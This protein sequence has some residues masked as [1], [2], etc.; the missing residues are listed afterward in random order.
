MTTLAVWR[1]PDSGGA[2]SAVDL[3]KRL[4]EQGVLPFDD[5]AIVSWPEGRT[6]P[7]TEHLQHLA[8]RAAFG[9]G[10]WGLFLGLLFLVPLVGLAV[11]ATMGAV[12]GSLLGIDDRFINTVRDKIKPGTSALFV[13][14]ARSVADQALAEFERAG[15]E[16]VSTD[17]SR[18]QED[19]LSEVFAEHRTV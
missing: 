9:G 19:H 5:A 15:A 4:R 14:T 7:K 1:F 11:G 2:R 10:F 3:L 16:L 13:M 6:K 8:G 18:E 12:V 17:L